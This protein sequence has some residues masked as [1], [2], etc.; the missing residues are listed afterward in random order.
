LIRNIS[1]VSVYFYF[2]GNAGQDE[3]LTSNEKGKR[4]EFFLMENVPNISI[5]YFY[6]VKIPAKMVRTYEI[7]MMF[8][9]LEALFLLIGMSA[10]MHQTYMS[11]GFFIHS[12][13]LTRNVLNIALL[14][15][16]IVFFL[17]SFRQW[18]LKQMGHLILIFDFN[19]CFTILYFIY[20]YCIYC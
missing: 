2:V 18:A 15:L 13:Y 16:F 3:G 7:F 11:K 17:Y 6:F 9:L 12:I 19:S 1:N 10:E 8:I 20:V 5:C 4:K 14:F